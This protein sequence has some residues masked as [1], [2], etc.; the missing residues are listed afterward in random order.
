MVIRS[1]RVF[2]RMSQNELATLSRVSRPTIDR[3]ESLRGIDR[4]RQITLEK[5][6]DVFRD[7][8][9]SV[10]IDPLQGAQLHL[11]LPAMTLSVEKYANEGEGEMRERLGMF[12]RQQ[13]DELAPID[14]LLAHASLRRSAMMERY[15]QQAFPELGPEWQQAE[16][17]S[18][19]QYADAFAKRRRDLS[20]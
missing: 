19:E 5:L 14:E 6:L 15:R 13:D 20:E 11:S 1:L 18:R 8:G 16:Q 7:L 4:A 9:V 12:H 2:F 17:K 10:Q 3:I